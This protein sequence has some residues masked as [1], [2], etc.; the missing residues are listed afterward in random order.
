MDKKKIIEKLRDDTEYYQGIGKDYFSASSL[1]QLLKEPG[2]FGVTTKETENI[3]LGSYFHTC[4][5]EPHRKKDYEIWTETEIRSKAYKERIAELGKDWI[6]KTSDAEKV[7]EW[8]DYFNKHTKFE[9]LIKDKGVRIEEPEIKTFNVNGKEYTIK[10]KADL[11][12][13]E[14]RIIDLK[15]C[16]DENEH[17]FKHNGKKNWHYDLQAYIYSQLWNMPVTFVGFCKEPFVTKEDETYYKIYVCPVSEE[18]LLE[19][20]RKLALAMNI[21]EDWHG[22]NSKWNV[23]MPIELTF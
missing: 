7:H 23:N 19:G 4:V 17:L 5:L 6:M 13:T 15:T 8:V 10:G 22:P 21:Y 1:K 11:I 20:K 9:K 3:V 16:T 14:N 12:T 2:Q 18:T